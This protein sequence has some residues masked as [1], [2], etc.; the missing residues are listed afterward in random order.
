MINRVNYVAI[1]GPAIQAMLATK[2]K[3]ASI[4]TGLRALVE[5]LVS[6]INGCGYCIHVH[7]K[8]ALQAG[9]PQAKLDGLATWAE[10]G[11]FSDAERAAFAWAESVTH[12][13][14]TGAPDDVYEALFE[15]FT[16][17]QVVDLTLI[18]AQINA[19]NR[20]AVSF[21]HEVDA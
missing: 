10:A 16:D 4:D 17:S 12:V 6:Q 15:H 20:L 18:I 7:S 3:I 14:Q 2:S 5:V 1:N 21:R 8:E 13:S 11:V 9:E 19:W